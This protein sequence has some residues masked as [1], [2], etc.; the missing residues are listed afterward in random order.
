MQRSTRKCSPCDDG[1]AGLRSTSAEQCG[2]EWGESRNPS[3]L[4]V[5][6]TVL[7]NS[8]TE[9]RAEGRTTYMSQLSFPAVLPGAST[10]MLLSLSPCSPA[11]LLCWVV[12]G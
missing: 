2:E 4:R 1:I 3:A 5:L 11:D 10:C 6:Q 12:S 9:P 8:A 7:L